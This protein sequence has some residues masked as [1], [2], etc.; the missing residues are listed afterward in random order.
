M[1]LLRASI[2]L[3]TLAAAALLGGGPT[4]TAGPSATA[5]PAPY[6]PPMPLL[7]HCRSSMPP[8]D[9]TI[10]SDGTVRGFAN[11]IHNESGEILFFR[12]RAGAVLSQPTPYTGRLIKA[13]WD[14]LNSTYVL[15]TR[16]VAD[17]RGEALFIG[18]RLDNT[19]QFAPATVLTTYP[20][21][22][23]NALRP[24]QAALVASAGKWWAIWAEPTAEVAGTH[25]YSLFQRHTLLGVQSRTRITYPPTGADDSAPSL[26]YSLPSLQPTLGRLTAIWVRSP[27]LGAP[28]GQLTLGQEF[29]Y[30]WERGWFRISTPVDRPTYVDQ[31]SYTGV[32]HLTWPGNHSV[33]VLSTDKSPI[34]APTIFPADSDVVSSTVA[35]SGQ[36]LFLMWCTSSGPN[37]PQVILA[38]RQSDTWSHAT[39]LPAAS[40]AVRVLAQGGKGRLVY[41][42]NDNLMLRIQS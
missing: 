34:P 22:F 25:T 27:Y 20:R 18:K 3:V 19:G 1:R 32:R 8:A 30:G 29:G 7:S 39:V 12:Y 17:T 4:A 10:A 9:A 37:G 23:P 28:R 24:I 36:N 2:T 15:F 31:I 16:A 14:G 13:A 21:D 35:V 41:W 6:G 38:E 5:A 40:A 42:D 26:A 33:G 11:C